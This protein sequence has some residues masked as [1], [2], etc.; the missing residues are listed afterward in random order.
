MHKIGQSEGFLGRLLRASLKT[1][2]LLMG[3]MFGSGATTLIISHEEM[4]TAM[5]IVKSLQ[6]SGLVTK[7]ESKVKR[8]GLLSMLLGTLDESLLGNLITCSLIP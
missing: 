4:N 2:L 7:I 8:G 3:K 6:E 5:K 1:G